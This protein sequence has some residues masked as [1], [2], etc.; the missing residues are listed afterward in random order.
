MGIRVAR[1]LFHGGPLSPFLARNS[2]FLSGRRENHG[3]GIH[4]EADLG[5]VIAAERNSACREILAVDIKGLRGTA[6]H[7]TVTG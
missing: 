6:P 7:Y 5:L 2:C 1:V 3:D 4:A